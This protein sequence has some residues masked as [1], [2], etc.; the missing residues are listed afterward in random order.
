MDREVFRKLG[1][2]VDAKSNFFKEYENDEGNWL[3]M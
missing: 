2:K 1:F 3:S